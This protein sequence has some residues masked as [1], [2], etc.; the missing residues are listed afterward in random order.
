M[1]S[2]FRF[3]AKLFEP[4][5]PTPA[6]FEAKALDGHW[7]LSEGSTPRL[8]QTIFGPRYW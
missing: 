7:S 2:V 8:D 4:A 1:T 5:A 3:F 6:E